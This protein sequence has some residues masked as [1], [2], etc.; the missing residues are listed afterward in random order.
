MEGNFLEAMYQANLLYDVSFTDTSEFEE[1]GLIAWQTIG[2][3]RTRLY[4]FRGHPDRNGI[5][6]LPCNCDCDLIEAVVAPHEDWNYTSNKSNYGDLRSEW[7]EQWIEHFK[8]ERNP[9]Y[10]SGHYVHFSKLGNH[11]I[12][13]QEPCHF[14]LVIYKG[15]ELDD[16]D[17]PVLNDKEI[18]AIATY[19]AYVKT[20]KQA[21][22]TMNGNLMQVADRLEKKWY[23]QLDNARTPDKQLTQNDFDN[24][25][26]AKTRWAGKVYGKSYKPLMK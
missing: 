14:V 16:D 11:Q 22:Q 6:N 10:A 1:I 5:I 21:M 12:Q 15:V 20:F 19:A 9:L 23:S 2:N 25:A 26:N 4:K 17:L 3:K 13:I 24:I 7:I 8:F 18:K